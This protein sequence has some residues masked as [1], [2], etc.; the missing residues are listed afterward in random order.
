MAEVTKEMV[1]EIL[2]QVRDLMVGMDHKLDELKAE[3]QAFRGHLVAV[4]QDI[5]NIY[6]TLTRHETRLDRIEKR[7][8]LIEPASI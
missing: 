7:L 5:H 4:Q 6:S 1:Y 3:M 2:R 8:G